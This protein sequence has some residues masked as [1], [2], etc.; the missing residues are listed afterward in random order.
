MSLN[1]SPKEIANILSNRE[2]KNIQSDT[3]RSM[4]S[5]QLY[6]K[7]GVYNVNQLIEKARILNL[8]P[9]IP[10]NF[11]DRD[12]LSNKPKFSSISLED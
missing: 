8:I 1:K 4:I 5:K 9:F 10:D 7:F 6:T 11:L 2:N 3:I 12:S